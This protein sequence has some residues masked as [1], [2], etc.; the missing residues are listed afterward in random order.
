MEFNLPDGIDGGIIAGFWHEDSFIMNLVL[1]RLAEDRDISV[2]VTSD[3]RGDYIEF[4]LA[5]CGGS[6]I[7][8]PDG[9]KSRRFIGDVLAEAKRAEK[10]IAAAMDGPLGPR[11]VPKSLVFYLS[12]RGQK[13]FV[14]FQTEYS[15]AASV[16]KRWDHYKIPLPF[17]TVTVTAKKF[18]IADRKKL[19]DF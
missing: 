15:K 12:E 5:R 8:L 3:E 16:K 6:A 17:T 2:I 11:R 4:L 19:L 9:A 18:G 13:E 14:A 10:S 1:K 7:R